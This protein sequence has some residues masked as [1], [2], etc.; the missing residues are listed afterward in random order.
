MMQFIT[1]R[2][3]KSREK[4]LLEAFGANPGA[5]G[6][7]SRRIESEG[8]RLGYDLVD[9]RSGD[10]VPLAREHEKLPARWNTALSH[11]HF[12]FCVE[13]FAEGERIVKEALDAGVK[14]I[15]LDEIGK[16]ELEGRGF[17]P[18][19]DRCQA[20][21]ADLHIGCRKMNIEGIRG[22]FGS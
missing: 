22:K 17:A 4:A 21:G 5:A 7:Y 10:S 20:A 13:G 1:K 15:F 3:G 19:I 2:E 14:A 12:S 8:E 18:L 9:L 11:G 16:L 6:F